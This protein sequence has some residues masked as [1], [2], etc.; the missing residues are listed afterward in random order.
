MFRICVFPY[1]HLFSP[2]T[3]CSESQNHN[4]EYNNDAR[5]LSTMKTY[6]TLPN[7][8]FPRSL[9]PTLSSLLTLTPPVPPL[10][11]CQLVGLH[12]YH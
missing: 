6:F 2:T 9:S 10:P 1:L 3:Q 12:P 4:P 7:S 11:S 8:L 5:H